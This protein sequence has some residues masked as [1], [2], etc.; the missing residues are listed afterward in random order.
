MST[1]EMSLAGYEKKVDTLEEKLENGIKNWS[2]ILVKATLA[3]LNALFL[4]LPKM[5]SWGMQNYPLP[6]RIFDLL[7]EGKNFL[8]PNET[9]D[10][11]QMWIL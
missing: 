8:K 6:Q 1:L 10:E 11:P 5:V 7:K 9:K 3:Q 2:E 4:K